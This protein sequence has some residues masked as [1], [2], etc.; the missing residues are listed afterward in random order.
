M[1]VAITGATGHLGMNLIHLLIK[2]KFSVK[3]LVLKNDP[4]KSLLSVSTVIGDI[5]DEASLVE[6]F[7]NAE[8]VFHLAALNPFIN[9]NKVAYDEINV[10]GTKNVINA[11][12]KCG[13]KR[14]VYVSTVHIFNPHPK[15]EFIDETRQ[16]IQNSHFSY[17][18]SKANAYREV[19]KMREILDIVTLFPTAFIGPYDYQCSSITQFLRN[20]YLKNY[21]I[22]PKG[23]FNFVDVRDVASGVLMAALKA[24]ESESYILGGHYYKIPE[25]LNFIETILNKK[26]VKLYFPLSVLQKSTALLLYFAK[27][28]K[29]NAL[30]MSA[31]AYILHTLGH[32]QKINYKKAKKEL[33]FSPRPFQETIED[34]YAWMKEY[35]II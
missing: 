22:F 11:C 7:K 20:I 21:F 28:T 27:L 9:K 15:H 32:H 24:N 3:A 2:N 26:N 23:G 35:K 16:I 31:S 8:I 4:F 14:L 5:T 12:L 30:A 6:C 10:S 34:T 25:L 18:I 33:G 17:D 19:L 29:S 13:V 1:Q